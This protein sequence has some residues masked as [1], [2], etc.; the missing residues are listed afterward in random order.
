MR[1]PKLRSEV[2]SQFFVVVV[3]VSFALL[4]VVNLYHGVALF[5]S[6]IWLAFVVSIIWSGCRREG[7][8]RPFVISL[9]GDLFGRRFVGWNPAEAQPGCIRFGFQL[10]SRRFVQQSIRIDRIQS[11]EWCT[12]QATGLAKRD[13]ND[14]CVL[15]WFSHDDPAR[16][17]ARQKWHR[18]PDQDLYGIGPT[19]RK[20]RTEALGLSFVS[21]LRSAGVDLI[22]DG[23][24]TCF[25]RATPGQKPGAGPGS[26]GVP[27]VQEGSHR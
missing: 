26:G 13:M 22:Q 7:G 14:W 17:K 19:D 3:V 9:I 21:F 23:V 20:E 24:S 11:V 8:M 15:L 6:V 4:A 25:V 16:A 1:I 18:N 27:P 10:F 12:G 5:A 2:V